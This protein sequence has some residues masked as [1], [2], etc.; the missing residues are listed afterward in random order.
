M[1]PEAEY[2]ARLARA[3]AEMRRTGLAALWITTQTDIC[4][5]TGFLTRFWASPS[6]PWFVVLPAAGDPVAVIPEI[7]AP[8]MARGWLRDIRTW[9]APR[10]ADD[11]VSLLA[12]ALAACGGPI[13]TPD[14]PESHLRMPLADFA[15]L[16]E[17][18][19]HPIGSDGGIVAA[20][21]AIKSPLEIERLKAVCAVTNRAFDRVGEVAAAGVPLSQVFRGFQGLLLEEG[22]D[23]VGFLAGAAG[24]EGY[25]DVI[26][27]ADDRP[28]AQG[29]ILMLDTGAVLDG[30]YSDFDR[31]FAVGA[32]SDRAAAA[33]RTLIEAIEAGVAAARPGAR[34]C[35]V[36][37][38]MTGVTGPQAA[39]FG[40]GLGLHLTEGL[41]FLESDDTVL[42]TGMVLTLEPYVM[43]RKGR[44]LVHE[45]VIALTGTGAVPLTRFAGSDLP[46]I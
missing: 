19:P 35:D 38:A 1:F 18:C 12:E 8:L 20:L 14:G 10:P 16:R 33:H 17:S 42:Q 4:Y 15:R 3:Q 27:P 21:R 34:A 11:G 7:G 44:I 22:A 29:D 9:P 40:H 25:A 37:R 23:W 24:P 28:L 36:W 2:R 46:V 30:Y 41:S 5:F 39:R 6:R 43:T 32:P 45:E 13:G 26:S 31:N